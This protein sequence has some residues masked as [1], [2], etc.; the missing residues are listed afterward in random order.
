MDKQKILDK[1][2]EISDDINDMIDALE[3]EEDNPSVIK[4]VGNFIWELK[5]NNL[6][7]PQIEEFIINYLM[8]YNK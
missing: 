7:I 5:K 1:L 8:F 4:D 6:C 2:T 3:N